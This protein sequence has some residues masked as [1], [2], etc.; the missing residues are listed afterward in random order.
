MNEYINKHQPVCKVCIKSIVEHYL[1][2]CGE[3][4]PNVFG[5]GALPYACSVY[6]FCAYRGSRYAEEAEMY[7]RI[8]FVS[9]NDKMLQFLI[10]GNV[11]E[12]L[13]YQVPSSLIQ[14][15][16]L[17]AES[18]TL[19]AYPTQRLLGQFT[20]GMLHEDHFLKYECNSWN[21][22]KVLDENIVKESPYLCQYDLHG[23]LNI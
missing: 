10:Y 1:P 3:K 2:V 23:P 13:F 6:D 4:A 21:A 20:N 7:N 5:P 22:R 16:E 19:V 14:T 11:P 8:E 18:T 9:H 15:L 12:I 17:A